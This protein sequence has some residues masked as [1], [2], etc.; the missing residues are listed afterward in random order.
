MYW[1]FNFSR[2]VADEKTVSRASLLRI[3]WMVLG[4]GNLLRRSLSPGVKILSGRN[5]RGVAYDPIQIKAHAQTPHRPRTSELPEPVRAG[6]WIG[7]EERTVRNDA[8]SVVE[9]RCHEQSA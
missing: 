2:R 3:G 4:K 8:A 9:R 1:R 5:V 6:D 7:G